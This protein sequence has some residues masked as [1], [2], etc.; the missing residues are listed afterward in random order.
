MMEEWENNILKSM[1]VVCL[2]LCKKRRG[3]CLEEKG[4]REGVG[5]V[6]L[7]LRGGR[8]FVALFWK[9]KSS[10]LKTVFLV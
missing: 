6:P 2:Q 3:G 7:V 9:K 1:G 10:A 5:G 8:R 4:G